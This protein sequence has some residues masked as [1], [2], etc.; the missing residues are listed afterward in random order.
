F[1]DDVLAIQTRSI[2]QIMIAMAGFVDV[3]DIKSSQAFE[4]YVVSP[5]TQRPFFVHSGLDK[6]EL[7]FASTLYNGYWYWIDPTDLRSKQV[8]TLMLYLT[9]LTDNGGE[10]SNPVLTIPTG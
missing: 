7:S 6:P 3:P 8:F 9:T 5:G 4:G 2:L 1:E 10:D